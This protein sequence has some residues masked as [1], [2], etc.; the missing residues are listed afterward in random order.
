ME[1][2]GGLCLWSHR[3][4]PSLPEVTCVSMHGGQESFQPGMLTQGLLCTIL[5]ELMVNTSLVFHTFLILSPTPTVVNMMLYILQTS[6]QVSDY[7][8]YPRVLLKAW[9]WNVPNRLSPGACAIME[10]FSFKKKYVTCGR[11]L[12]VTVYVRVWANLWL[13]IS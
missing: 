3:Q 10:G 2:P 7:S 4:R 13:L 9:I 6:L 1:L 12:K 8:V 11:N 5:F